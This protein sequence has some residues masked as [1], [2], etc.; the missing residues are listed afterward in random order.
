MNM[1]MRTIASVL[2][3]DEMKSVALAYSKG[4]EN[5]SE[6]GNGSAG[7]YPMSRKRWQHSAAP[8]CASLL[9]SDHDARDSNFTI[10]LD[11]PC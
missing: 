8:A 1:P 6:T 11:K 4:P 5:P 2:T 9:G 3:Q 10:G 7:A